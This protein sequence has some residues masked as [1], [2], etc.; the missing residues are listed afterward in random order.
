MNF[1]MVTIAGNITSD[2]EVKYMPNGRAVTEFSVAINNSYKNKDGEEVKETNFIRVTMYGKIVELM[3]ENIGKGSPVV[4]VGKLKQQRW[5]GSDGKQ[6]EKILVVG[7]KI[8]FNYKT[9][10]NKEETIDNNEDM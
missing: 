5:E 7:E 8:H 1:N 3:K 4:I 9:E 6:K 10:R 2:L